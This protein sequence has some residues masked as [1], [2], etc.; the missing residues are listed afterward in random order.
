MCEPGEREKQQPG[1]RRQQR[2][3]KCERERQARDHGSLLLFSQAQRPA[4]FLQYAAIAASID[5][6]NCTAVEPP[7]ARLDASG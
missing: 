5:V 4:P 2:N 7:S 1:D 6:S 3:H